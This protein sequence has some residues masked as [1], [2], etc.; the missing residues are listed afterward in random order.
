V[1]TDHRGSGSLNWRDRTTK[2]E[3]SHILVQC[4]GAAHGRRCLPQLGD[5]VDELM[6]C[7]SGRR[8][9]GSPRRRCLAPP[10][11]RHNAGTKAQK[12]EGNRSPSPL[13]LRKAHLQHGRPVQSQRIQG[14]GERSPDLDSKLHYP[15]QNFVGALTVGPT[16]PPTELQRLMNEYLVA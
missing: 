2:K 3:K 9:R 7:G 15:D 10:R 6:I 16:F 8:E 11:R 1:R 4:L 12:R 13:L 5:G 14:G